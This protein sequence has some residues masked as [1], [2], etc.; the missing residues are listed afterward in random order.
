MFGSALAPATS[1]RS[2]TFWTFNYSTQ[3][4]V[5]IVSTSSSKLDLYISISAI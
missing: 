2:T 1:D 4:E 5:G 3:W